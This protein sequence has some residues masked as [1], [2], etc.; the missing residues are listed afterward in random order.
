MASKCSCL[1]LNQKH[2]GK[3]TMP[4]RR[5]SPIPPPTTW[6]GFENLCRDLWA[7]IWQDRNT[8]KNGRQSQPQH[9][10]DVFGQLKK[11]VWGGV[12]AKEKG[13]LPAKTI[14]IAE[15]KK[16]VGKAKKFTPA[17]SEYI[18]A[19]TGSRDGKVQEEARKLTDDNAKN[20]LFSVSV[21]SWEDI[22]VLLNEHIDVYKRH[23]PYL[24]PDT[25]VAEKLA[26]EVEEKIAQGFEKSSDEIGGIKYEVQ[27][28]FQNLSEQTSIGGDVTQEHQAE[29]DFAKKLIDQHKPKMAIEYLTPIKERIW[30]STSNSVRFRIITNIAAA[31]LQLG[32]EKEGARLFIEAYQYNPDDEKALA[33]MALAYI[34]LDNPEKA[35][36]FVKKTLS[37]NPASGRGYSMLIQILA[38][39]KKSYEEI[40]KEIP[41]EYQDLPE[42]CYALGTVCRR[43]QKFDEALEWYIKCRSAKTS[44]EYLVSEAT[45]LLASIS[46][47]MN[48]SFSKK[49]TKGEIEKIKEAVTLF[50]Q[51]WAEIKEYEDKDLKIECLVNNGIANMILG[52]MDKAAIAFDDALTLEP[53]NKSY[54]FNRA[55]VDYE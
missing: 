36:E 43:V 52:N 8:Q 24:F 1:A 4:T 20:N 30:A 27:K 39:E 13:Q 48:I 17:L 37:K 50:E 10:V 40:L 33:N 35:R 51:A 2:K 14:T 46:K 7:A 47:N 38:D 3:K 55:Y 44:P 12:Q 28:G 16:E 15:L 6:E 11:G 34:L 53:D 31:N 45:T 23:Y 32:N 42:I 25:E 26:R 21:F 49:L 5:D 19:T 18:L 9:G 22:E 41:P 54:Q 29:I